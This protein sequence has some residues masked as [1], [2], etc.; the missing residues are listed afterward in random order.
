M[1][2]TGGDGRTERLLEVKDLTVGF[3]TRDGT[4]LGVDGLTLNVGSHERLGVVGESGSGKSVMG[5]AILGMVL[6]PGRIM[7]GSVRWKGENVL[8]EAVANRVRGREIA[9]IFQDPM[10]SLNPLKTVGAQLRELLQRR[11]GLQGS[12]IKQRSLELLDMVGIAN[13]G[14]RL[15]S[16][17]FELSGG[18]RQRVMIA[19]AL[20]CDPTLL[21]ADE[22]TTGLDV[23]IQDQI[24]TLLHNLS[25]ELGVS[26]L[27]ITHDL[28]VVAQFCDR[29]QVMYA[30]R[31]VERAPIA[32]MFADPQH[33]YSLG[34]LQSVPRVD[35]AAAELAGIPGEPLDRAQF[36]P[37]CAFEPRCGEA[38][39]TCRGAPPPLVKIAERRWV[40]CYNRP[41]EAGE[42]ST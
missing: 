22:P 30:G 18:M 31:I 39:D 10:V 32:Q 40:A 38:H 23:T 36:P 14:D 21:I 16:Y 34:L 20:A 27:M 1:S 24:L 37:G 25:T 5:L 35:Q 2:A 41:G 42:T 17:A 12:A 29:V 19:T 11:V 3:P 7:G 15:K 33:P 13:P 26:V 6:P 28:G 4:V 9:M 8:D